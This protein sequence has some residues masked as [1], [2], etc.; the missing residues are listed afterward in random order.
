ME[1]RYVAIWFPNLVTDWFGQHQPALKETCFVLSAPSHG[2]MIVTAASPKAQ[3]LFIREGMVLADARAICPALQN[4]D[5]KPALVPTLLKKIAAWCIRFTPT[6]ACDPLG[7]IILDATGCAHL[8]GSEAAYLSDMLDRLSAKG[9]YARATM[10]DTI[11]AAWA[12]CRYG[13]EKVI[14]KGK[15]LELLLPLPPE[16]LRLD[17]KTVERLH[18]LGFTRIKNLLN[19]PA[20]S[21]RRRFGNSM[22]QRLNQLMGTEEEYIQSIIPQEPYQVRLPCL[23]PIAHRKGIEIALER[24]LEELC[25]RLQREGKGLR[26]AYFKGYRLDGEVVGVQ[27]ATTRAS[28]NSRHLFHLFELKLSTIQPDLGIELFV[29]EAAHVEDHTPAQEGFWKEGSALTNMAIAELIDNISGRIPAGSIQRY[30]PAEHHLPENSF[31]K[32]ASLT[33]QTSA[34]WNTTYP[35]PVV[36]LEKPET[37]EVTAPVPD[38]PPMNFRHRGKLHTIVRADG[39]K[40]LE[41]EWWIAEGEHRDYYIV[42]DEQGFRYWLFRLG[43]YDETKKTCWYL[44][45]VYA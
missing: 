26:M 18:K 17:P 6:V 37:I 11:G 15:Q 34:E 1:K 27:I 35:W 4:F 33:E 7:G 29:L 32:A 40:R 42:E 2:K 39:P 3:A 24:S 30:L 9:Y 14:E 20:A 41:Q 22:L 5:D 10:A 36:L 31:K 44:H 45:G 43:H 13:N 16:A 21:L 19:V 23:E 8:W 28:C 25:E 38:Y 12:V